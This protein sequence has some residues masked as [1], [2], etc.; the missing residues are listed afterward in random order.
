MSLESARISNF[1]IIEKD[2]KKCSS[3]PNFTLYFHRNGLLEG[4]GA[5][6]NAL[7]KP[8]AQNENKNVK[9]LKIKIGEGGGGRTEKY[10]QKTFF[11]HGN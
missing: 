1:R 8:I 7:A 2:K 4:L 5:L 11:I 6:P 10:Q 9:Y 3:T